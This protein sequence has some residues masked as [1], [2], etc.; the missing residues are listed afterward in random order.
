MQQTQ[1]IPKTFAIKSIPEDFTV[2]RFLLKWHWILYGTFPGGYDDPESVPVSRIYRWMKEYVLPPSFQISERTAH[3]I[4][5]FERDGKQ[6]QG[7]RFTRHS[8][9]VPFCYL[10]ELRWLANTQ[11]LS[12]IQRVRLRQSDNI[13]L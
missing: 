11:E 2:F 1:D 3:N 5:T 9:L 4:F 8:G 6:S 13:K 10:T 12:P 7:S